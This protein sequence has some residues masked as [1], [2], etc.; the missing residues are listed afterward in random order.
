MFVVI[1]RSV[2]VIVEINRFFNSEFLFHFGVSVKLVY[3]RVCFP[4][5]SDLSVTPDT[6]NPSRRCKSPLSRAKS[7]DV[8]T[9]LSAPGVGTAVSPPG[10]S[11]QVCPLS[12]G[13]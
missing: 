11:A 3:S 9:A 13:Q 2:F 5:L 4:A 7:A 6:G 10:G 12:L 8:M 1:L